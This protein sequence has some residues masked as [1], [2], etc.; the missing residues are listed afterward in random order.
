MLS[1]QA[2]L[3]WTC[4]NFPPTFSVGRNVVSVFV[5]KSPEI[6]LT[7]LFGVGGQIFGCLQGLS[8][9]F[10]GIKTQYI[11]AEE[12]DLIAT[13]MLVIQL[14]PGWAKPASEVYLKWDIL[15][16]RSAQ[17]LILPH[18]SMKC[19]VPRGSAVILTDSCLADTLHISSPPHSSFHSTP[20]PPHPTPPS[21]LPTQTS[22][23]DFLSWSQVS[24]TFAPVLTFLSPFPPS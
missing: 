2:C 20:P 7:V 10:N 5:H 12:K 17:A 4:G 11:P 14:R 22:K 13:A 9:L 24:V 16:D 15:Q 21:S 6:L 18:E 3:L 23:F 8:L 19:S 1:M